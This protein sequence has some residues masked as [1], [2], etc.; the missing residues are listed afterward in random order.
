MLDN[1][2][3]KSN[4]RRPLLRGAF[5]CAARLQCVCVVHARALCNR[6]REPLQWAPFAACAWRQS[7]RALGWCC[8]LPIKARFSSPARAFHGHWL[9][10]RNCRIL[11]LRLFCSASCLCLSSLLCLCLS[12]LLCSASPRSLARRVWLQHSHCKSQFHGRPVNRGNWRAYSHPTFLFSL[13]KST[14]CPSK[15][16]MFYICAPPFKLSPQFLN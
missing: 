8:A 5:I 16:R 7:P 6:A 15:F 12:S 2:N 10:A 1:L 13:R 3:Y 14:A 4:C 9:I 11:P